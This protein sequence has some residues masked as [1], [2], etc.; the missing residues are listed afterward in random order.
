MAVAERLL[1]DA[2]AEGPPQPRSGPSSSGSPCRPP[3]PACPTPPGPTKATGPRWPPPTPSCEAPTPPG[4]GHPPSEPSKS[5][6][7]SQPLGAGR[8]ATA[9]T[10]PLRAPRAAA[11]PLGHRAGGRDRAGRHQPNL[12]PTQPHPNPKLRE[13]QQRGRR[14]RRMAGAGGVGPLRRP[15][16]TTRPSAWAVCYSRRV[17]DAA[18]FGAGNRNRDRGPRQRG[19]YPL[20]G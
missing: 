8:A 11:A 10:A 12:T 4:R 7:P 18:P 13:P 5:G 19:L 14:H 6:T 17:A 3:A 20:D 15:S 2:Y 1:R 16:N 9:N